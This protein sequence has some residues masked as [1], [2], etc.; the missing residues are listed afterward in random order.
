MAAVEL[1]LPLETI[2][3]PDVHLRFHCN[4]TAR[5]LLCGQH[6][7]ADM[8]N[9]E[10]LICPGMGGGL[11]YRAFCSLAEAQTVLKMC[12]VLSGRRMKELL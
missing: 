8:L 6:V 7:Q 10:S 3:S 2:Q 12:L 9:V 1:I 4:E 11:I 5:C